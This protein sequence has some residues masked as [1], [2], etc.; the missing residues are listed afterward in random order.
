M[1]DEMNKNIDELDK[2]TGQQFSL[3]LWFLFMIQSIFHS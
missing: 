2:I 3:F 1:D